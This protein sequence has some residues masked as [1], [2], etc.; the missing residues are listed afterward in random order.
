MDAGFDTLYK[1]CL[2]SSNV[3]RLLYIQRHPPSAIENGREVTGF[4]NDESYLE[5]IWNCCRLFKV[6]MP[7]NDIMRGRMRTDTEGIPLI[8]E[9][10]VGLRKSCGDHDKVLDLFLERKG[11]ESRKYLFEREYQSLPKDNNACNVMAAIADLGKPISNDDLARII[12]IGDSAIAD[13]IASL[14][15]FFLSTEISVSGETRYILNTVTSQ[16]VKEKNRHLK[17]GAKISERV[18]AFKAGAQKNSKAIYNLERDLEKCIHRGEEQSA[19]NLFLAEY[20]AKATENPEFRKLKAEAYLA[21]YP[22]QYME[23]RE[24]FQ[25]CHNL[26]FENAELFR[27]WVRMERDCGASLAEQIRICDLFLMEKATLTQYEMNL[28]LGERL[29]IN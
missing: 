25:F 15:G 27:R 22:P 3:I 26:G 6:D 20:P 5:F 4:V 12:Q 11:S 19:L 13:S 8:L 18:K 2:R 17:L 21:Q 9:T 29:C 23:A 28:C 10:I 1:I 7:S 24:E 14:V 16:Y